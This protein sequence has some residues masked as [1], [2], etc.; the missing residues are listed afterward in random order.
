MKAT[1]ARNLVY[2]PLVQRP[3]QV[4]QF[5]REMK[6]HR[7]AAWASSLGELLRD[8]HVGSSEGEG[9]GSGSSLHETSSPSE[10]STADKV[11]ARV[12]GGDDGNNDAINSCVADRAH[13]A[14]VAVSSQRGRF[15]LQTLILSENW[16]LSW[17]ACSRRLACYDVVRQWAGPFLRLSRAEAQALRRSRHVSVA[18]AATLAAKKQKAHMMRPAALLRWGFG[19]WRRVL[20]SR[21]A[22]IHCI[23]TRSR[24]R[25]VLLLWRDRMRQCYVER[26]LRVPQTLLP[27]RA[28]QQQREQ[29]HVGVQDSSQMLPVPAPERAPRPASAHSGLGRGSGNGNGGVARLGPAMRTPKVTSEPHAHAQA[30]AQTQ[31]HA[32]DRGAASEVNTKVAS[33]QGP[34]DCARGGAMAKSKSVAFAKLDKENRA[35]AAADVAE[36]SVSVKLERSL[37]RARQVQSESGMFQSSLRTSYSERKGQAQAQA[38]AQ[39]QVQV[40]GQGNAERRPIR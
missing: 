32:G 19:E 20:A 14:L 26:L 4:S 28:L 27:P 23:L 13:T 6:A 40:R 30:Q 34:A 11:H 22:A 9:G 38:Q 5:H 1:A 16:L 29:S 25:P 21:S 10:Y 36:P 31:V 2:S 39:V 3:R 37:L 8:L 15:L 35:T 18:A 7:R 12:D 33:A 24:C 17:K